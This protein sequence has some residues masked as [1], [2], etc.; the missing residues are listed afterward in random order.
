MGC[1]GTFTFLLI[2]LLFYE[3]ISKGCITKISKTSNNQAITMK[4]KRKKISEL[5]NKIE[6]TNFNNIDKKL[7]PWESEAPQFFNVS[8]GD[9]N[10]RRKW[11][12]GKY[13]MTTKTSVR[14]Q[15]EDEQFDFPFRMWRDHIDLNQVRIS[16]QRNFEEAV[17]KHITR[18]KPSSSRKP[19]RK[20]LKHQQENTPHLEIAKYDISYERAMANMQNAQY[21]RNSI[22]SKSPN[23]RRSI[24]QGNTI[25]SG[26][27]QRSQRG[28][29]GDITIQT[30]NKAPTTKNSKP[31]EFPNGLSINSNCSNEIKRSKIPN[32]INDK[33]QNGK[34]K[35]AGR[36]KADAKQA[37]Q[38]NVFPKDAK[39][40]GIDSATISI[41][42]NKHGNQNQDNNYNQI[43]PKK[44]IQTTDE[45]KSKCNNINSSNTN[46][47]NESIS[48]TKYISSSNSSSN[49][50]GNS[51][52]RGSS[53]SSSSKNNNSSSNSSS[54]NIKISSNN[55]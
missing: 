7:L 25:N 12:Q 33:C 6:P 38:E 51:N 20:T 36:A 46:G 42:L 37:S 2:N 55:I 53:S 45:T 40:I 41:D 3:L 34:M 31:V 5:D 28:P 10:G 48:N 27:E 13:L 26:Q 32:N 29:L 47:S 9:G 43:N 52:N 14:I 50:T 24:K 49:N 19:V 15:F 39:I 8:F 16:N 17:N 35:V 11:Y 44:E 1:M 23:A 22:A 4:R 18:K 21:G 54:N 30:T